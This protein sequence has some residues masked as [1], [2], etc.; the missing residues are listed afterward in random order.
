MY[1]KISK[2]TKLLGLFAFVLWI[3]SSCVP[4]KQQIY[5]Q[6]AE[7]DTVQG[8]FYKQPPFEFKLTPGNN[9]YVKITSDDEEINRIYGNTRQQNM[10]DAN[11][12]LLSYSISDDGFIDIPHIGQVLVKDLTINEAK[13]KIEDAVKKELMYATV[14]V[15]MVNYNLSVLGE[16]KRPAMYKIYQERINVFEA[17]AMAGDMNIGAKR[18]DVILIRKLPTG[19]EYHHLNLLEDNFLQSEYYYLMPGDIVYVPPVK[20]RNYVFTSAPYALVL[21]A[22]TTAILIATFFNR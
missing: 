19:V 11:L 17:I 9:L 4:V 1:N 13:E 16:V 5:L 15:K 3:L 6:K 20:N 8:N 2:H 12:Y 22:I 18:S 7:M 21:S 10:Q 14:V